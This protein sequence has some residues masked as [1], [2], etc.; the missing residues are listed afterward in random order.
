MSRIVGIDLGTTNSLVA[1]VDGRRARRSSRDA[2][3]RA[4]LPSIVAF[5]PGGRRGRRGGPAPAR[6]QRRAHRLL[7]QAPH[8]PR[9][10]GR[11][12]RAAALPLRVAP[13]QEVVRHPDRRPRGHAARGLGP[14]PA[15]AQGRARRRTSASP[16][17]QAVITVPAY[18][19]DAQR[20]ATKDAG[21]HRRARRAAH[22]QRADGGLA[23]LRAPAA[24]TGGV[25]AVYDLGGG[26]FDVSILRVKDGIFEVLATNGNTH[27]GGDDFD[28]AMV[29]LARSTT[30]GPRTAWTSP[31]TRRRCRSSGWP[32]RRPSAGCRARS[33]RRSPSRSRRFTYRREHRRGPSSRRLIGPLVDATLGPC[34]RG[35]RRRR[36]SAPTE[37]DEVVLVGGSTRMPLVRRRVQELFGRAPHSRAEPRRGGGPRRGRSGA[38]PGRRA[39]PTCCC[40]T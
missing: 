9:L 40:S 16:V 34:R 30:S 39:S 18:F 20:Q 4:L 26:T 10:R 13:S 5:T 7:G 25:I 19:N 29:D 14:H 15:R 31:A 3:G 6:A 22:R 28:R 38:D 33:G 32:P 11:E 24:G 8:G 17:E 36:A 21:P 2:E 27:L 1:Y 23:R 35:A 12:G 37:I